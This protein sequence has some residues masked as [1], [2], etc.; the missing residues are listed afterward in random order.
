MSMKARRS[1]LT[2]RQWSNDPW[3]EKLT[4]RIDQR[5]Q[6]PVISCRCLVPSKG[7]GTTEVEFD[8]RSDSFTEVVKTMLAADE[9]ATIEALSEVLKGRDITI[10]A[11]GDIV[12]SRSKPGQPAA[13]PP[14]P[15][16]SAPILTFAR[17]A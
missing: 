14:K 15:A 2:A 13:V 6:K 5:T 16:P 12:I 3:G 17:R 9:L 8:I 4:H 11:D 1:G 10:K 7:G